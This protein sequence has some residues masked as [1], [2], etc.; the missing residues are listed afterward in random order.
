M[1]LV[2]WTREHFRQDVCHLLWIIATVDEDFPFLDQLLQPMPVD[3]DMF[4]LFMELRVPC[5]H[6]R[7]III[8]PDQRRD[9]LLEQAKFAI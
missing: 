8:A 3:R 7:P 9:I 4:G 6:N 1:S 5:H 2:L